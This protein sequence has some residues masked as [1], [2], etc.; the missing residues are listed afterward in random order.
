MMYINQTYCDN[1]FTIYVSEIIIHY[2]LNLYKAACQ[3]Y[4]NKLEKIK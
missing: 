4:L 2:T 3:I 1:H